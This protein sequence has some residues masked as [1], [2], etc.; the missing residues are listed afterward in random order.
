MAT[1]KRYEPFDEENANK[2]PFGGL[3]L[4]ASV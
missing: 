4:A 2:K 1:L 3:A